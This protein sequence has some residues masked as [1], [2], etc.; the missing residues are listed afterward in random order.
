MYQTQPL[1]FQYWFKANLAVSYFFYFEDMLNFEFKACN[2]CFLKTS[3][4]RTVDSTLTQVCYFAENILV[5]SEFII[6]DVTHFGNTTCNFYKFLFLT[7][8]V[9]RLVCTKCWQW[10]HDLFK[11]YCQKI[12]YIKSNLFYGTLWLM[13]LLEI[14]IDIMLHCLLKMFW[15]LDTTKVKGWTLKSHIFIR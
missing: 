11:S 10:Y 9:G 8:T 12:T 15:S 1:S 6:I 4:S 3:K 2:N 14:F 5:L 13:P 7:Y